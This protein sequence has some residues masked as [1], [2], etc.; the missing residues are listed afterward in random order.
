MMK[1]EKAA[2]LESGPSPNRFGAT[3]LA[4]IGMTMIWGANFVIAKTTFAQLAPMAFITLRFLLAS[5][6]ILVVLAT[7]EPHAL[8]L[9]RT[10][11]AR[12]LSAGLVGT[13]LYQPLFIKGLALTTASNSALILASTPAFI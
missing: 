3:D 5:A 12:V 9:A 10:D 6:L 8:A 7:R 13:T 2:E 11:F 1:I 4:L